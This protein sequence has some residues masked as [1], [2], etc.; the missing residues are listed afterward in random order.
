M[1]T[2]AGVVSLCLSRV[3]AG[4][5]YAERAGPGQAA[6]TDSRNVLKYNPQKLPFRDG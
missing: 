3:F 5:Q 2:P 4:A 1:R 6:T